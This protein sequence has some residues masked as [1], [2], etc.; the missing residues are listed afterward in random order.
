MFLWRNIANYPLY[1]FLS[2]ALSSN[3]DVAQETQFM[4][5]YVPLTP[6]VSWARLFK[7]SNVVS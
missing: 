3:N 4:I 7:T 2:G 6:V 1:S 5:E